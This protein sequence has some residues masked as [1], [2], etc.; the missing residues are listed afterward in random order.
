MSQKD[1][2]F[3]LVWMELMD[4]EEARDSFIYALNQHLAFVRRVV[5][6]SSFVKEEKGWW[7][8]S[9]RRGKE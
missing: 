3:L 4:F 7:D 2:D 6:S 8:S 1:K 9:T 5:G